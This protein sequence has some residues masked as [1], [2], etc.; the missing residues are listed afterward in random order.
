[1][2]V[3]THHAVSKDQR[4][5]KPAQTRAL[6]LAAAR[7]LFSSQGYMNTS[8]LEVAHRAGVAEGSLFY[9]FGS[10]KNLLAALGAEHANEMVEAMQRGE[11]D[12]SRLEPGII[13]A[14]AFDYVERNGAA[15]SSTGLPMESAEIQTFL[16]ANRAVVVDFVAQ[17]IKASH[18][19]CT[20]ESVTAE[21]AEIMA[22][23]SYAVVS[24]ALH[25][26]YESSARADKT[27]VLSETIRYV[28]A[29]AGYGHMTGIPALETPGETPGDRHSFTPPESKQ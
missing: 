15:T 19:E 27:K 11:T 23:F 1:M 14:R 22:S 18:Q 5:Y 26:V 6:I 10:K 24:D 7:E 4:R 2:A 20:H 21:T 13:I 25:R 28:R 8:S 9:H 12:L 17:C 3:K 29:A 16:N